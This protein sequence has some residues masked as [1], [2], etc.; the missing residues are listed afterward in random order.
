MDLLEL[1]LLHMTSICPNIPERYLKI[2]KSKI[3]VMINVKTWCQPLDP[4]DKFLCWFL[5][6]W[7][8]DHFCSECIANCIFEL[9]NSSSRWCP[10]SDVMVTF[11]ERDRE[12]KLIG[13]F[14]DR[15]HRGPYSQYKPC[16]HNL[17]IGVIIFSHIDNPQSTGYNLPKKNENSEGPINLTNH[18]RKRLD[19]FT[20]GCHIWRLYWLSTMFKLESLQNL[21][22]FDIRTS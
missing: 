8:S 6:S 13:L 18:W 2:W 4:S 14:G 1:L 22:V 10:R 3:K 11:E 9:E 19:Q 12:I 15:G 21:E 16:N 20:C 5:I 17:Y 7:Q